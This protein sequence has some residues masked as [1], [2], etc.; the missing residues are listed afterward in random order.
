MISGTPVD[1]QLAESQWES[2]CETYRSRG[3]D[4]RT[5]QPVPG[6]PELTFP[7]DSIFLF[8]DKAIPS[9]H[10]NAIRQREV[11]P[12][13][14]LAKDEGYT[15]IELDVPHFE[16]NGDVLYWQDALLCGHGVRNHAAVPA[17]LCRA[18]DVEVHEFR[19]QPPF[20]HLDSIVCPINARLA[21]YHPAAF[22][23]AGRDLLARL[24]PELLPVA[25]QEAM[26]LA[27]NSMAIG[28]TV[29]LS[30][31][32]APRLTE[33]LTRRGLEIVTIDLS[34]SRK[35]GAGAKCMTLEAYRHE[36][37]AARP[38]LGSVGG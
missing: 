20:F 13:L 4:V 2:L 19:V 22:D 33:A 23:D 31:P 32:R 34:E 37:L 17:A 21:L 5:I 11:A 24:W 3:V 27:C 30:T 14:Q 15:V 29:V 12:M 9:R 18:L 16:G 36:H 26:E 10:R 28:D 7:G 6:L 25:E 38:R 1:H 35:A 8:G